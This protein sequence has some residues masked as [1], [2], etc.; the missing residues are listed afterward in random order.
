MIELP[1]TYVLADQ[2]NRSLVG[3]R[4]MNVRA[5][6]SP[7]A[8][9]WFS[10]D[11]EEYHAKLAGKKIT[12]A[13]PGT[14]YTC[15]GNT[16]IIC[17]NM[18]LVISTP[19]KYHEPGEKLPVKHQLL[20]EFEDLSHLSCTVQMWGAMLCY[21]TDENG[22]P[23]GYKVNQCPTPL[24]DEFDEAYFDD[25]LKK[26]KQNLS[27]KAFLATEQ[28]IPGLGNGVLQDILFNAGINPKTKLEKLSDSKLAGMYAS[29]KSTL[30]D[31]T[32]NGGRDTEK[33]LFGH[34]GGY[35]T[36]LSAKTIQYPCTVC[37]DNLVREAYLG[38]NIYY[39]P[40]CQQWEK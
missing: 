2:I 1:E 32:V 26:S 18:L 27:A 19:I 39:C 14:G 28:R 9:A 22:L 23:D 30:L 16:E 5:N 29:V 6:A 33:D 20:I 3:R 25:L 15:G 37:G 40:T 13:N 38:G 4:I 10:G 34:S 35:K 21:G 17:E 31:M 8:F 7:H 36:R 11:P 24:E 12:A